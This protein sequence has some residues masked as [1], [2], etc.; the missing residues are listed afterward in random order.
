VL[1]VD[2]V[3]QARYNKTRTSGVL[4]AKLPTGFEIPRWLPDFLA[5][6]A[7]NAKNNS[8]LMRRLEGEDY[9]ST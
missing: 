1:A 7:E 5:M 6:W 2:L 4:L 3:D 9:A 8:L